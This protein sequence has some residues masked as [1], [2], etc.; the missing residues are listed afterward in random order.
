MFELMSYIQQEKCIIS[1]SILDKNN[2]STSITNPPNILSDKTSISKASLYETAKQY[3]L[4]NHT[5]F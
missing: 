3:K 4:Y 2:Y 1:R 5:I